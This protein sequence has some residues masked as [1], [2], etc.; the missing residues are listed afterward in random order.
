MAPFSKKDQIS[1]I[2]P[3]LVESNETAGQDG[4]DSR[5]T[6]VKEPSS[7]NPPTP[8]HTIEPESTSEP[9]PGNVSLSH[10]IFPSFE[11]FWPSFFFFF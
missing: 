1:S 2:K 8:Q 10:R 6:E 11:K 5:S 3:S 7:E 4:L 9:G